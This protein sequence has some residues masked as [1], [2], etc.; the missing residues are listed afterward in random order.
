MTDCSLN[1]CAILSSMKEHKKALITVRKA[2]NFLEE[3]KKT[4]NIPEEYYCSIY[5]IVKYNEAVEL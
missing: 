4:N 5:P 1:L 2:L 3:A